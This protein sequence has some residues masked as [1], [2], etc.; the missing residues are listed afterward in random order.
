LARLEQVERRIQRLGPI[1][2]AAIEEC[3]QLT[4]RKHYLDAQNDDLLEALTTLENAIRKIDR[5]TRSRFRETFDRVNTGLGELF[6]RL[7]GGGQAHL[8][9]TGEPIWT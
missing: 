3:T 8:D 7:F 4:E 9:L 2:L 6:P 5:E 1:N